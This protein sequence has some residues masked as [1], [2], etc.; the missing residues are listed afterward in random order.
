M[1]EIG[2]LLGPPTTRHEDGGLKNGQGTL[3]P[4]PDDELVYGKWKTK[5]AGKHPLLGGALGG[6]A[7]AG[8]GK[9]PK[10]APK[11]P[12]PTK[13]P[14]TAIKSR[15]VCGFPGFISCERRR[16]CPWVPT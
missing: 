14:S 10:S 12:Q 5:P 7:P 11:G 1:I 6:H 4:V 16:R 2:G 9:Y 15:H 3:G 13:V 8:I